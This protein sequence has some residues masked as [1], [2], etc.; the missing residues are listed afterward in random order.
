[1]APLLV[2]CVL[3]PP[4]LKYG[5]GLRNA[6]ELQNSSATFGMANGLGTGKASRPGASSRS[7]NL[8]ATETSDFS[9][10]LQSFATAIEE[11]RV[12]KSQ[13]LGGRIAQQQPRGE[14]YFVGAFRGDELH[15]TQVDGTIVLNPQFHNVD[16]LAQQ[17]SLGIASAAAAAARER[18]EEVAERQPRP[19]KLPERKQ[20]QSQRDKFEDNMRRMLTNAELENWVDVDFVDEEYNAAYQ[21]FGE[22]LFVNNG[23]IATRL[24][25]AETVEGDATVGAER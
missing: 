3:N 25:C 8:V 15:L 24:K 18:G 1:M 17:H 7:T 13:T 20:D 12:F 5:Y 16:A 9:D 11:G 4:A 14:R 22:R 10:D 6:R 23:Q 19:V 2:Q 21:K